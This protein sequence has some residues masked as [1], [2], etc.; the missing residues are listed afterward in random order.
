VSYL[1][2]YGEDESKIP[3]CVACDRV[4]DGEAEVAGNIICSDCSRRARHQ[5]QERLVERQRRIEEDLA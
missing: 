4:L 2:L 3:R 1:P 5:Q